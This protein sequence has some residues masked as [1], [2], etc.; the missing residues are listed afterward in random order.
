MVGL[1]FFRD[2]AAQAT[3]AFVNN[4]QFCL[5]RT[6]TP[7]YEQ[8]ISLRMAVLLEPI[9]I[10]CSYIDPVKEASDLLIGAYADGQLAGCC[11]LTRVSD[12]TVQL[13]Q[14]AVASFVQKKG[15][16]A[17]ILSFAEDKALENGYHTLVMHARD[18]VLPFYEKCGYKI[19]GEQFFEVG[20]G[21]HKMQKELLRNS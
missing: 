14:M 19:A 9:G 7:A 11:I 10:P 21:H 1:L 3:F 15:V 16:G 4:L 17:A 13:R 20:I 8:M 6:G 12:T 18:T 5:L 2:V